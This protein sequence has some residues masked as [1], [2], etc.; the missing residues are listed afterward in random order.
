MV[1]L[2]M[3]VYRRDKKNKK[4]IPSQRGTVKGKSGYALW[5]FWNKHCQSGKEIPE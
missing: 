4:T 2:T 5:Q 1:S 3:T